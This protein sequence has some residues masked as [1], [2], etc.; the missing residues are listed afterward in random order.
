MRILTL[1]FENINSLKGEWKIDFTQA[2]FDESALFAI[3]GPTG[4]GK[5]TILDAICLALYHETPRL[6]VSTEQNQLMTRQTA[7]CMAEVEFEVKGQGYRAFWSQ[8]RA[9]SQV[10]GKLQAPKA[11]LATMAGDILAEKVQAVRAEIARITGLDFPRFTKSMMLSQ[12]Q[13]AAF[14][15]AN[16]NDRAELLEELTGTEI[17]GTISEN[18]YEKHKEAAAQLKLLQASSEGLQLLSCDE[19]DEINKKLTEQTIV[20]SGLKAEHQTIQASIAWREKTTGIEQQLKQA[21]QNYQ[22]ATEKQSEHKGELEQLAMHQ[23]AVN[24]KADYQEKCS[25]IKAVEQSKAQLTELTQQ[26]EQLLLNVE[27][28]NQTIKVADESRDK[29]LQVLVDKE[30]I[31]IEQVL[32]LDNHIESKQKSLTQLNEKVEKAQQA[33]VKTTQE[34]EQLTQQLSGLHLEQ[35]KLTA[36]QDKLGSLDMLVAQLPHIKQNFNDYVVLNEQVT[37]IQQAINGSEAFLKEQQAERVKVVEELTKIEQTLNPA[38]QEIDVLQQQIQQSFSHVGMSSEQ[39][40]NDAL[41]QLQQMV[42]AT[43]QL[44]QTH[45]YYQQVH[46][47]QGVLEQQ[48]AVQEEE[49]KARQQQLSTMR[50]DYQVE[51]KQ[52]E[53]LKTIVEQQKAIKE[54]SDYRAKLSADEACPLCGSTEHPAITN[55]QALATSDHQNE[56]ELQTSKVE[57]LKQQGTELGALEK[58]QAALMMQRCDELSS[59]SAELHLLK[60]QWQEVTQSL[61][62]TLSLEEQVAVSGF[63][64][65]QQDK[66]NHYQ[67]TARTLGQ[68]QQQLSERKAVLESNNIKRNQLESQLGLLNQELNHIEQQSLTSRTQLNDRQQEAEHKW[69]SIVQQ[70]NQLAIT[71]PAIEHFNDWIVD[72]AS[73]TQLFEQNQARLITIAEQLKPLEQQQ[74]LYQQR[75]LQEDEHF[76]GLQAEQSSQVKELD[77]LSLER[78]KL[79]GDSNTN[80]ERKAIATERQRIDGEYEQLKH[81]HQQLLDRLKQVQGQRSA[82]EQ[83]QA[84]NIQN[85]NESLNKWLAILDKSEFADDAAFESALLSDETVKQLQTLKQDIEHQLKTSETL[86]AQFTQQL[87]AYYQAPQTEATL[88]ELQEQAATLDKQINEVNTQVIQW[89]HELDRDTKTRQQ[90]E[91]MLLE[92]E[93]K[94]IALDDLSHLNSLIGSADGAK[95]RRFAQGLTL[96]HLVYL[97]NQQLIR[98]HGRYQLC[99]GSTDALAL[100]VIDTWQGDVVRDTKTL[101]GGESF[102]VSLAL[103]LALSDL[104]SNKTQ[105]DSLFLDEG[106]GTLDNDTLEVALDALDN[107]NAS[108]KMIGVISHVETLKERIDV[109]IKVRKHS[110]LGISELEPRYKYQSEASTI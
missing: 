51:A 50:K 29:A 80:D 33:K 17:Y 41:Y 18:V 110:G 96:S 73:Q 21:K 15:N 57:Q 43:H 55:Y 2:P 34:H 11:E 84:S 10:D 27:Q 106:F 71:P 109:Q 58:H 63:L 42:P 72:V 9:K 92:I 3:T 36:D 59:L 39:A 38:N 8:R 30:Q 108:G 54:L 102:L 31:I 22:L 23:P 61:A 75:L 6:K 66:L 52:L 103:A 94:R 69:Q 56:F 28:S 81:S 64:T 19:L 86:V 7:H 5:T 78:Q 60:Q 98:L 97:A 70:L 105:I 85:M 65:E 46:A 12:G 91:S 89:Q 74:A 48:I 100:Q 101:S 40:F 24:L 45:Q 87:S 79:L 82:I 14:L 44:Q 62:V 76:V 49:Q 95:F 4:A 67:E 88:T 26:S 32:P 77:A 16:A 25:A 20:L 1:R 104:V 90:Q 53:Q 35:S 37:S 93:T 99:N 107:L 47:K 83:Q 68:L 13:F